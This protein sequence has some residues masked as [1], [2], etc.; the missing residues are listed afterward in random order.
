MSMFLKQAS[1][2]FAHK[3]RKYIFSILESN[4]DMAL[5]WAQFYGWFLSENY[6]GI[7]TD[8]EMELAIVEKVLPLLQTG[9]P[10]AT[11]RI[12]HLATELY[13]WGGH[14]RAIEKFLN[15]QFGDALALQK[16]IPPRVRDVL[17]T[18]VAVFD[19]LNGHDSI[20]TIENILTI[21]SS[22]D[23]IV[24]H[25]HPNDILS[26]VASVILARAGR[27]VYFYNHADHR[28]SFG[29]A[30]AER[31]FEISKYGWLCGQARGVSDKQ[32]FVGIPIVL[33]EWIT[34]QSPPDKKK[35]LIAGSS[36]NK[37]L[38]F[39]EYNISLFLNDLVHLCGPNVAIHI[40]GLRG[41]EFFFKDLND[42]ARGR[43]TFH[44]LM[45]YRD[46]MDL[47]LSSTL[48]IDSLPETNG[49]G[50]AEAVLAGV[51]AFGI[52]LASGYS[53]SDVL[54]VRT[55][56]L[57]L[58]DISNHL[59]NGMRSAADSQALRRK[60]KMDQSPSACVNRALHAVDTGEKIP[61]PSEYREAGCWE[62]FYESYWLSEIQ[63][64]LLRFAR[65][66]PGTLYGLGLSTAELEFA[67]IE[68]QP[69][70]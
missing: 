27:R 38:P 14:T 48:Y 25:I 20:M 47:L 33:N 7:Y 45:G 13:P 40:A 51:P 60:M 21:C 67:G 69:R 11:K 57:L 53:Y 12:I 23:V 22:Y 24:L 3:L 29:F 31:I 4:V 8:E 26:A 32:T 65:Y 49:T 62:F 41:S 63:Q 37:F 19:R 35:I 18:E 52:D 17:P 10:K 36:E 43:I 56:D 50:F 2:V 66:A 46:Y 70:V 55:I 68:S 44:G 6:I 59:H 39:K 34:P 54:R 61:L 58:K 9:Y 42:P 64:F 28:F 30:S 15:E 1:E 5:K 16:A